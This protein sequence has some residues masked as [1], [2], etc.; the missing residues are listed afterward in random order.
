MTLQP[1]TLLLQQ[2][3]CVCTSLAWTWRVALM[4]SVSRLTVSQQGIGEQTCR[5]FCVLFNK[6]IDPTK[7]KTVWDILIPFYHCSA[8]PHSGKCPCFIGCFVLFQPWLVTSFQLLLQPTL[9]SLDSSYWRGWRSC[10]GN[11]NPVARFVQ[12]LSVYKVNSWLL[13]DICQWLNL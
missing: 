3:T 11:W 7:S 4:W 6:Y 1:W 5:M 8:P 10:L 9:S 12:P 13:L 2:P